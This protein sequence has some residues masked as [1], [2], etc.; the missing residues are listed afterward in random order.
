MALHGKV[1]TDVEGLFGISV[2]EAGVFLTDFLTCVAEEK[3]GSPY[4]L[5]KAVPGRS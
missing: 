5:R 1:D 3:D 4:T 2:S